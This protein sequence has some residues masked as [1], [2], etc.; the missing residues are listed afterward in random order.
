MRDGANMAIE[1]YAFAPTFS[2]WTTIEECLNPPVIWEK[3]RGW[4][5]TE[6]FSEPEVFEFPEGIGPGRVRERRARGGAADPALGR[7]PAR[8]VQVRPR[9]RVHHGPQD[10]AP[11]RPRQ[12]DADRRARPAGQ[13]ARRRRGRAAEPRRA[14]RPDDREDLRRAAR[15]RHRQGRAAEGDL[16]LPRG[17]QRRHDGARRQPG[18]RL[19]DRDQSRSSAM[20]L[21][22]AGA[23]SG[24]G[25]LGPRRSTR[26]RSSSC[27]PSTARRTGSASATRRTRSVPLAGA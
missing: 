3:D 6:P 13:P 24:A 14:R 15:D 16:H 5:T 17:R 10:A 20:E 11:A 4:F 7:L 26:S 22:A 2:I 12:D 23:W 9:R 18:G 1:G 21:L 25:V 27:S 19:A 8:D